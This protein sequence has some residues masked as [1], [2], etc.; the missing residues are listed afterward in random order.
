MAKEGI[1]IRC[2]NKFKVESVFARFSPFFVSL[3]AGTLDAE[4][5]SRCISQDAH[6][7][8][9]FA[10]AF[11]L[12]A[13]CAKENDTKRAIGG[14]RISAFQK[15]EMNAMFV[16]L[17]LFW[18]IFDLM[19]ERRAKQAWGVEDSNDRISDATAKYRDFLLVIASGK[20]EDAQF[21]IKIA[22]P[23]KKT[24]VAVYTLGAIAPCMRLYAYVY[25][26]IRALQDP[27]DASHI[28]KKWINNYASR[29]FLALT[30]ETEDLLDK[31]SARMTE[32]ELDEIENLYRQA[33]KLQVEF[34]ATQ[35][36]SQ[37][38]LVPLSR[39]QEL[40]NQKL[41]I[42]CD[43]DLTCSVTNS[44]TALADMTFSNSQP[45]KNTWD[46]L[47][48]Q[49]VEE[50]KKFLDYVN[51]G[52]PPLPGK[53]YDYAGLRHTLELVSEAEEKASE[54][55]ENSGLL[56]GLTLERVKF[57]G[58]QI[59]LQDGC[60][61]ELIRSAFSSDLDVL[62]VHSNE[63]TYVTT[64]EI[65][66]TVQSP[67]EKLQ[68]FI[69]VRWGPKSEREHLTVCIGSDVGDFLC[70]LEADIGIV[71]NASARMRKLAFQFGVKL[72]PLFPTLVK[73]Q[74]EIVTDSSFNWKS[75]LGI[76]FMVSSWAEIEAFIFGL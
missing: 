62:N 37:Q 4:S 23:F 38:T 8:N 59:V 72:I 42:F 11:E 50:V 74:K 9:S 67:M 46:H 2:W 51:F 24:K 1:S 31:L 60:R 27:P 73:K 66:K 63:L 30:M 40:G 25:H 28:Y 10:Q 57:V 19:N 36:V 7:L 64:G 3:A 70:L 26:E 45:M 65:F 16:R 52:A 76:L 41:T 17:C 71:I 18:V 54:R 53:E 39:A 15:L 33:L 5:F 29:D 58:K 47:R 49:H 32:Q 20:V 6:F 14:L 75:V 48:T 34:F 68:S 43:F 13:D 21:P 22:T 44:S 61:S 12:A 55:M 35:P 56:Q 69:D